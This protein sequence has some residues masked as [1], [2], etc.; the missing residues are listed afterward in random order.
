M[1]TLPLVRL[2]VVSLALVAIFSASAA[3]AQENEFSVYGGLQEAPHSTVD[4]TDANGV[5]TGFT[6]GWDG[7]SFEMPPYY[8]FRYTRW[9]NDRFGW[10]VEF[11]H[12]KIYADNG[13]L[14]ANG[15][16]ALELTDGL[17]ILTVNAWR[18]WQNGSAWTPY[19]GGG[20]GVAIPH[21]DVVTPLGNVTYEYQYTGPAIRWAAGVAYDLNERWSMFAEYGGTYSRNDISLDGGGSMSTDVITNALNIG[22]TFRF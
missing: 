3:E 16:G 10:G 6:A 1:S 21:V 14:A 7:L 20:I 17:N 15:F 18:R 11:S 9:T 4:F 13:T 5:S 2:L 12:E 8:G 22:L 19:V